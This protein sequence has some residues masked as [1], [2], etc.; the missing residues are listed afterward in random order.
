MQ[1]KCEQDND[2]L[3]E[4]REKGLAVAALICLCGLIFLVTI[5]Y[6]KRTSGL[7]F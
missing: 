4:K 5:F 3:N 1:Y 7:D 6:L 2:T